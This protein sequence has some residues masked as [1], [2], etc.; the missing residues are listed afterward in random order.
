MQNHDLIFTVTGND[1]FFF[2]FLGKYVKFVNI[3]KKIMR[4]KTVEKEEII[5]GDLGIQTGGIIRTR[6]TLKRETSEQAG[7]CKRKCEGWVT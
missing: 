6:D 4:Y 1:F 2:F 5:E 7:S 3:K